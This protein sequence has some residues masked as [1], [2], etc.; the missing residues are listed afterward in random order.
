VR[1]TNLGNT[2]AKKIVADMYVELV[3]KFQAPTFFHTAPTPSIHYIAPDLL[4]KDT[5]DFSVKRQRAK[6]EV[7]EGGETEPSPLTER[8]FNDLK[9][10]TVYI[11]VFGKVG[12]QDVY[13]ILH[14]STICNWRI[15]SAGQY[16]SESCAKYDTEDEY[17][18]P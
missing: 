12:Y 11:A 2:T 9:A 3:R 10:G 13:H 1:L 16:N 7:R 8:E 6:G 17:D 4:P 5:H 15:L 14:W 18:E